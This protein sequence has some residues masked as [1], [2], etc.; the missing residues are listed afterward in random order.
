MASRLVAA[1]FGGRRTQAP[2][3]TCTS[4]YTTQS[5]ASTMSSGQCTAR[6][7]SCDP[8]LIS[9]DRSSSIQFARALS[10]IFAENDGHHST[11]RRDFYTIWTR[12]TPTEEV[13][14]KLL[15]RTSTL[16]GP[17]TSLLQRFGTS[18]SQMQIAPWHASC[19][20]MTYQCHREGLHRRRPVNQMVSLGKVQGRY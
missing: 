20:T 13:P 6:C 17:L 7:R 8:L 5:R 10:G 14:R 15:V 9:S 19:E 12:T 4:P 3:T 2:P 16:D 1:P 18:S 11:L